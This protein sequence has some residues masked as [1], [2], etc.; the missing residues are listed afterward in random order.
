M[1]PDKIDTTSP[2]LFCVTPLP[3]NG[4]VLAIGLA[5]PFRVPQNTSPTSS[6]PQEKL[7]FYT[8]R[9]V[10]KNAPPGHENPA[11]GYRLL[12]GCRS[13]ISTDRDSGSEKVTFFGDVETEKWAKT[14]ETLH[15]TVALAIAIDRAWS[16]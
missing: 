2:P 13:M 3:F 6:P 5:V 10:A 11:I 4:G 12:L 14:Q 7:F 15:L 16:N 1:S 9:Q 8:I